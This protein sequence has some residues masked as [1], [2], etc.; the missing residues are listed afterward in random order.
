[1]VNPSDSHTKKYSL[2]FVRTIKLN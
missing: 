2:M 1:M